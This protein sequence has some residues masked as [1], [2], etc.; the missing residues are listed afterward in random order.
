MKYRYLLLLLLWVI[1][2]SSGTRN[3]DQIEHAECLMSF[4]DSEFP[5]EFIKPV[6]FNQCKEKWKWS[7][8]GKWTYCK[9]EGF[10]YQLKFNKENLYVINML[11]N[12]PGSGVFSRLILLEKSETEFRLLEGIAGGDRCQRGL[13]IEE[14]DFKDG[15]LHYAELI[16]PNRLMSWNDTTESSMEYADCM[17]CC[18]GSARY[19]YDPLTR[20]KVFLG[21]DLE[22]EKLEDDDPFSKTYNR[23][24]EKGKTFLGKDDL[25]DFIREVRAK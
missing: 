24:L 22:A 13:K 6:S 16:T 18:C 2:C 9:E 23:Y 21:I 8:K 20:K 10:Y 14:V 17:V 19:T 15:L 1:F 25:T 5:A 7:Q 12:S 3:P 4:I 11:Y